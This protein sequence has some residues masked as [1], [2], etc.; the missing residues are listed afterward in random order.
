MQLQ[1]Q[2]IVIAAEKKGRENMCQIEIQ[3]AEKSFN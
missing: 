3:F 1:H 2:A